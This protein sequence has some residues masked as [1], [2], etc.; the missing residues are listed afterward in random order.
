MKIKEIKAKSIITKSGL[1]GTDFVINPYTGCSHG[2]IYCY[3]RFMKRFTNHHEPW[4]KFIDVKI[5]APDLIPE[6]VNRYKGK[7][8]FIASVTDAYQPIERKYGLM[9]EIL[10]RL[11][12]LEPNLCILTKSD[13]IIRDI[14]LL[15]RF[16]N[17]Q[18]GVSLTLLDD[19]IRKEVEPLASPIEKRIEVVKELKKAGINSYIFLSPMFPELTDWKKIIDKTKDFV[20]EFWFENLNVRT[21]NWPDIKKWLKAKHPDLLEKYEDIYSSVNDYWENIEKEIELFGR[22]NNLDFS[23]YFHHRKSHS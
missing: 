11:I 10:T 23:I 13:L 4:G 2:C 21:T 1:P 17:C 18:A 19:E 20:D 6:G 14:D 7:S 8:I 22:K 5:N 3:A 16:K 9:R 15:K 12:P